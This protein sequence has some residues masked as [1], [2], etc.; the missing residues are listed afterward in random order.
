M[1][2]VCVT[3]V[4]C[5]LTIGSFSQQ[6]IM[7]EKAGTFKNYKYFT[8]DDISLV[9]KSDGRR[10]DGEITRIG[11]STFVIN[12]QE[13]FW[14]GEVKSVVRSRF[15]FSFFGYGAMIGG[16]FY[17][18]LDAI[19]RAIN[20]DAPVVTSETAVIGGALIGGGWL[21]SLFKERN[22]RVGKE[23]KWRLRVMPS[24]GKLN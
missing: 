10:I 14:V 9:L 1:R 3:I 5:M 11:D 21:L 24:I 8:G 13:E 7:L 18:S 12:N 16:S 4:L 19:N 6:F 22:I 15:F 23:M 20:G 2:A 17:L